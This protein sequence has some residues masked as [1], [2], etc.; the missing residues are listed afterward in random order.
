MMDSSDPMVTTA[1]LAERLND[2]KLRVVDATLY[3]PGDARDGRE[4]YLR[5]HLPGAVFFDIEGLADRSTDLPHM[6][7]S[8]EAFADAAGALGVNRGACVVVY[9]ALG[10]FSAARG[11]WNFRVMGH[12]D[13]RVLDGGL[14]KWR[15]EGR[16]LQSGE[17][18]PA[19]ARFEACFRP[20]LVRSV[21]QM[22]RAIDGD[23]QVV[24]A[25]PAARF[26]GEAPEPRAGLRSG[27]MPGARSTPSASLLAQ[28][29]TLL[30]GADLQRVFE[31]A[32]VDLDRPTAMT[33]GSG[34]TAPIIALAFA[35][36]G[37]E[38]AVYD[39]SWAE[40]GALTDT[41][42]ASPGP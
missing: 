20:E 32:G 15:A 35:R 4:S 38:A 31:A 11:W 39:G 29:G 34:V 14:P 27:H 28:D 23:A 18:K 26:R 12:D 17:V 24:D 42:I 9:D 6:L 13:V 37:R 8:P 7:A 25:R 19:P 33:C 41:P 30:P 36:L 40:W 3:P 16:P 2:P 5:E 21:E 10:L 1:W 22:R